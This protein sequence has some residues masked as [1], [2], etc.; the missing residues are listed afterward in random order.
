MGVVLTQHIKERYAERLRDKKDKSSIAI[1]IAQN[2]ERIQKDIEKMLEFGEIIYSGKTF[3]T[4]KSGNNGI[5]DIYLCHLWILHVDRDTNTVITMYPIDLG[6]GKEF[7]DSYVQKVKEKISDLTAERDK[8]LEDVRK[9]NDDL[10]E[11]IN[12]NDAQI[13]DHTKIAK[14]LQEQNDTYR[15]MI[16]LNN[17]KVSVAE[18][19]L[20]LVISKLIGKK[21]FSTGKGD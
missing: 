16:S 17:S 1:F 15:D 14:S 6:L 2:E 7:N 12:E 5:V 9:E 3:Q 20:R 18:D 21:A 13:K 11:L 4:S 19:S 8:V 10:L